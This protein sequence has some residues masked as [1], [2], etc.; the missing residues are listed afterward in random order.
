VW[1]TSGLEL[2][3]AADPVAGI[4]L[5]APHRVERLVVEGEDVVRERSLV[6]AD[7]DEIAR[8]QRVQARRF[9]P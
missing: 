8:D 4:V 9:E 7:E 6:N 1:S 2:G 3:G 5:S